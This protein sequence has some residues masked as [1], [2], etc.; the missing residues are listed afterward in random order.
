MNQPKIFPNPA[1][2]DVNISSINP[3]KKL[4]VYSLQGELLFQKKYNQTDINLDIQNFADGIYILE[5]Q[6]KTRSFKQKLI[7]RN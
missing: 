7:V 2:S 5:L 3:I 1:T 6:D 4:S